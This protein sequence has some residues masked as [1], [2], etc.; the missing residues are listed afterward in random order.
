MGRWITRPINNLT[1]V[2]NSISQGKTDLKELPED[3]KDEI[4]QLTRSFN[5][6]VASLRVALSR[7]R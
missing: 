6:L 3:R 4:G 2:A 5:R 1:R 7:R